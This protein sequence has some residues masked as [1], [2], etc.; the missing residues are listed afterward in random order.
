[1]YIGVDRLRFRER[2]DANVGE[3]GEGEKTENRW[4]TL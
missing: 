1:M 4:Q 2:K 3:R